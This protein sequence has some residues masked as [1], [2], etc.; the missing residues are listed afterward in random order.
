MYVI[1]K[2]MKKFLPILILLFFLTPLT[3]YAAT[4][5]NPS[6]SNASLTFSVGNLVIT[7]PATVWRASRANISKPSGKW[8]W[9]VKIA[10]SAAGGFEMVGVAN[11]SLAVGT[12]GNYVGIDTNSTGYFGNN[13]NSYYNGVNTAF[14]ATYG[15]GDVIGV[16]LDTSTGAVTYYKNGVSQGT[17]THALTGAYYPAVSLYNAGDIVSANFGAGPFYYTP[18]AGYS[19]F[20]TPALNSCSGGV[21]TYAGGYEIH[22]FLLSEAFTCPIKKAVK[23]LVVAG[24]G[25]GGGGTYH[26]AGGGAGGVLAGAGTATTS[27]GVIIGAAGAGAPASPGTAVGSNGGNSVL[28]C[29]PLL[30]AAAART[31]PR[32]PPASAWRAVLAAAAAEPY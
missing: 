30:A 28:G 2:N 13:G 9:E 3:S 16:A 23:Y 27:T 32:P 21:V 20:D 10:K 12:D 17:V 5:W 25:G 6:D 26:G 24:G 15:Q 8:Y 7:N 1:L 4:T 29:S 31:T 19:G 22:T 14:G 11:S 18:P